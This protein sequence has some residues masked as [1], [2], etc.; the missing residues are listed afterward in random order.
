VCLAFD[1]GEINDRDAVTWYIVIDTLTGAF[2]AFGNSKCK[3]IAV[4]YVFTIPIYAAS[5]VLDV[6]NL[7]TFA[8]VYPIAAAQLGVLFFGNGNSG[9]GYFSKAFGNNDG[10]SGG[11]LLSGALHI[12]AS[13]RNSKMDSRIVTS[14]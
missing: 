6:Q 7:T 10:R 3:L 11:G 5:I 8:I 9:R 2:L 13:A 12:L 14:E 1:L 4:G